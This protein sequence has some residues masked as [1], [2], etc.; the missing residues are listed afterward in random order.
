M[1]NTLSD[2]VEKVTVS[3]PTKP[4]QKS[5]PK[6]RVVESSDEEEKSEPGDGED[7]MY[8]DDE[9]TEV[10]PKRSK[11]KTEKKVVPVGRNGLKK[12]RVVK[13]KMSMDAKGYMGSLS[14]PAPDSRA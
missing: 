8:V 5:K 11:K 6:P 12:K 13:S 1:L 14:W 3:A 7:S 9:P 2:K 10:K 4:L